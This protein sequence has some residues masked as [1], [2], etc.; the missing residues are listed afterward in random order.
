MEIALIL[1]VGLVMRLVSIGQ[2]L[3]LDE[4]TTALVS[5][6]SFNQIF[7]NFLPNDFHPP[8]YYLVMKFWVDI[9][10]NSEISLR[11]PSVLFGLVTVYLTYLIAK[12]IFN[13]NV[14][15][16]SSL[17]LSTS[18]LAIYYSQEARMYG[19]AAMLVALAVYL[20]IRKKW[21]F[22]SLSLALIGMCDYVA[23]FMLPVFLAFGFRNKKAIYSLIPLL[24]AFLVWQPIFLK[25]IAVGFLVKEQIPGWWKVL[26]TLTF[27]NVVLIADKFLIGR[28]TFDNHFVYGT[29]LAIVFILFAYLIFKAIKEGM[30]LFW[31]LMMPILIGIVVAIRIPTLNYFRF[32]FCLPPMYILA[33]KGLTSLHKNWQKALTFILIMINV[34]TAGYYL[35][36]VRFH[37]EDWRSLAKFVESKKSPNSVTMFLS[38]SNTEAYRYY[39]PDARITSPAAL[40]NGYDEI[41]LMTYLSDIYDSGNVVRTR[42]SEEGYKFQGSYSFNGLGVLE[43]SR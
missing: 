16:A 10:G 42:I 43:Y 4:A 21:L 40:N 3:W 7:T 17:L 2:S 35:F 26:G 6:M 19:M 22:F 25:Q 41:W 36:S 9:F 1:L 27:K 39:A 13:K 29:V 8:L 28:I 5:K 38:N 37:K 12:K 24:I 18:G 31:W 14:A 15:I 34:S 20:Y 32:L 33:A 30:F 23:L 11:I